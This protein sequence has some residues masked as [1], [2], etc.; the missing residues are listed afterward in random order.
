MARS[1]QKTE[2]FPSAK[3][4]NLR[5]SEIWGRKKVFPLKKPNIPTDLTIFKNLAKQ[6]PNIS[7]QNPTS[8]NSAQHNGLY[9]RFR[10]HPKSQ[11][12]ALFSKNLPNTDISASDFHKTPT[13]PATQPVFGS[14]TFENRKFPGPHPIFPEKKWNKWNICTI[15]MFWPNKNG[16][17]MEQTCSN[18]HYAWPYPDFSDFQ[19]MEQMGVLMI[20]SVKHTYSPLIL[21]L[22]DKTRPHF[23]NNYSILYSNL[24]HFLHLA[25]MIPGSDGIRGVTMG[26]PMIQFP[27]FKSNAAV[28]KPNAPRFKGDS[29]DDKSATLTAEQLFQTSVPKAIDAKRL[30][31]TAKQIVSNL[32]LLKEYF[33][34]LLPT[35]LKAQADDTITGDD[36]EATG[37]ISPGSLNLITASQGDDL[38]LAVTQGEALKVKDRLNKLLDKFP[39]LK[40]VAEMPGYFKQFSAVCRILINEER[41]KEAVEKLVAQSDLAGLGQVGDGSDLKTMLL[42]KS[43][44]QTLPQL[45]QMVMDLAEHFVQENADATST[46]ASGEQGDGKQLI[47]LPSRTDVFSKFSLDQGGDT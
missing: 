16:T 18:L 27:S 25:G 4:D 33:D 11:Q 41:Q 23:C 36:G 30:V 17:N 7:Q 12:K 29:D 40:S 9:Q 14:K 46:D 21:G 6:H 35:S 22:P 45:H 31:Q 44:A 47:M 37:I 38:N 39:L 8:P 19:N 24:Y 10:E 34:E 28:K 42:D 3:A 13:K 15:S 2:H 32:R 26:F 20:K 5:F 1:Q 43:V